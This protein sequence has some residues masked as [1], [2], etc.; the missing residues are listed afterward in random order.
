[1]MP[2]HIKTLPVGRF[3]EIAIGYSDGCYQ[4]AVYALYKYGDR[5][6][7][8]T[9]YC[10][11]YSSRDAGSVCCALQACNTLSDVQNLADS[12][13]NDIKWFE[14]AAEC[15]AWFELYR[16]EDDYSYGREF[17]PKVK[18]YLVDSIPNFAVAPD[19]AQTGWEKITGKTAVWCKTVEDAMAFLAAAEERG[20]RWVGG[21]K[22]MSN[23]Y[24]GICKSKTCYCITNRG[25]MS[26]SQYCFI[27]NGYTVVDYRDLLEHQV[28][29]KVFVKR[30]D[31]RRVL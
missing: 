21:D 26:G 5:F 24:W 19:I 11:S 14:S 16:P 9:F 28:Y 4:E 29:K 7:Y 27:N 6:G 20:I 2:H 10:D 31:C 1:M 15:L 13:C 23:T 18:K 3:V 17:V 22:P 30:K 12:L 25:L 8:F